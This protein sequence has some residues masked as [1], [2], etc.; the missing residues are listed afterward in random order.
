MH[1][2]TKRILI[3]GKSS[4]LAKAFIHCLS[5][6]LP[7]CQNKYWELIFADHKDSDALFLDLSDTDSIAPELLSHEFDLAIVF[8]ACTNIGFCDKEPGYAEAVNCTAISILM[9]RISA[10]N[11]I[12]F[13]TNL[14]FSGEHQHTSKLART[15]PVVQYGRTKASME[16][17][18]LSKFEGMAAIVRMTKVMYHGMRPV[19]GFLADLQNNKPTS[20][21]QDMNVSP[22]YIGDVCRFLVALCQRFSPGIYHLSGTDDASYLDIVSYCAK[23]LNLSTQLLQGIP[24]NIWSP[25]FTTLKVDRIENDYG[26]YA[27]EYQHVLDNLLAKKT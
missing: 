13:S 9:S 11:W 8:A 3:I 10:S 1:S 24:K 4:H 20:V 17:A 12:V 18:V 2:K 7:D 26:F 19:F 14:V 5:N 6:T 27:R 23:K 25:K 22:I 15:N 16:A 21:F